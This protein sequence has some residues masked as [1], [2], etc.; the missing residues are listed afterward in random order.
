M[1][2]LNEIDGHGSYDGSTQGTRLSEGQ[3]A[4]HER[5][6]EAYSSLGEPRAEFNPARAFAEL[7]GSRPGHSHDVADVSG[8]RSPFVEVL[9][10]LPSVRS[11]PADPGNLLEGNDLFGEGVANTDFAPPRGGCVPES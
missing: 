5:L 11:P 6:V 2:A 9:V 4:C 3:R 7:C 8:T 1:I 10:S